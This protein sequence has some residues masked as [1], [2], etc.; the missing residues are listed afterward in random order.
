VVEPDLVDLHGKGTARRREV[1]GGVRPSM[2]QHKRRG[3]KAKWATK[4]R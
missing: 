3:V 1:D 2:Q 4:Q